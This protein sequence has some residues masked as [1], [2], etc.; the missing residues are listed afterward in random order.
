[1]TNGMDENYI[2]LQH[3]SYAWGI[4]KIGPVVSDK[5]ISI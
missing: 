5:K 2:P 4:I 3:T 1:M